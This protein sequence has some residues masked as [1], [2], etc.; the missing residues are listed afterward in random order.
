MVAAGVADTAMGRFI[1]IERHV[2]AVATHH[3]IPNSNKIPDSMREG[4][5][6]LSLISGTHLNQHHIW[7]PRI[8][9]EA[10][11]QVRMNCF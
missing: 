11:A 2:I 8:F 3:F 10:F 5:M 4:S 9:P 1:R 6:S 7:F